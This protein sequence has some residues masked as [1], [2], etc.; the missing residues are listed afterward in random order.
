VPELAEVQDVHKLKGGRPGGYPQPIVDHAVE[1]TEAL[2][3][4][5]RIG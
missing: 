3:R 1:R 4:Y 2:A 5:G